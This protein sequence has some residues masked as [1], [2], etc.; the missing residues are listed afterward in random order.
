MTFNI[1]EGHSL[2][3]SSQIKSTVDL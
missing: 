1:T 2:I 3:E